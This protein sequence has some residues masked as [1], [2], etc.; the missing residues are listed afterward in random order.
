[1]NA[2]RLTLALVIATAL[3]ISMPVSAANDG[4]ALTFQQGNQAYDLKNYEQALAHYQQLIRMGVVDGRL[5]YNMGNAHYRKGEI[6]QAILFYSRAQRLLP[7]D[8]DIKAN[9]T[10]A[11]AS[12][13][14]KLPTDEPALPFLVLGWPFFNLSRD[15][16]F[17]WALVVYLI[18][19]ALILFRISSRSDVIRRRATQAAALLALIFI[20]VA[21]NYSFRLRADVIRAEAVVLEPEVTV[22]S[23]PGESFAEIFKVHAGAEIKIHNIRENWFHVSLTNELAGWVPSTAV[24][25]ILQDP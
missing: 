9:L 8:P 25:R 3:L 14:D 12:T 19:A 17:A 23:G 16:L 7:G 2:R 13:R 21:A 1:M 10:L 18:T 20:F 5:Y 24:E 22:R 4:L 6:G 15:S 11:R